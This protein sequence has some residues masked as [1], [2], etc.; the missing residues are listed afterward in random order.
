MPK[1]RLTKKIMG[2]CLLLLWWTGAG[3]AEV[4][5]RVVAIVNDEIITMSELELMAKSL[6]GMTGLSRNFKGDINLQRQ[7]LDA[8]IDQKL[9]KAEA[10]RRGI[11][12]AQKELDQAV[13]DF[14]RQNRLEDDKAFN[15]ALGK[16][17]L[18]V[19]ELKQKIL[20]QI[21]HERLMQL[22]VAGKVTVSEEEL[23]RFYETQFPKE[24][25]TRL[26]LKILSIPFPA[27]ATTAQKEEVQK[28]AEDV[29]KEVKQ[30]AALE[31][32]GKKYEISLQDLGFISEGDL[33]PK[34]AQ[35]LRGL[36]P[37]EVGPIQTPQGF[38]LV[39]LVARKSGGEVR[40]YDEAAP[41][42]RSIL[43]R[44]EMSKRFSEWVR[45]LRD[46]AAV[47]IML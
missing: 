33:D 2:V 32:L 39:Q 34:L 24:G 40:S 20:D 35:F 28:K 44:Q 12:V 38:Q 45:G 7:M 29:L 22:Q 1:F 10:K 30:G 37:K 14:R 18:T 26:H 41:Q 36:K 42:I 11:S 16:A 5:D 46:K 15:E 3:A 31:E 9:A 23:R 17:G 25:G 6:E 8:L 4:V 43:M 27:G 19:N 47:K 13:A 21:V